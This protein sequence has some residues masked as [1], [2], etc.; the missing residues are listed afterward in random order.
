MQRY[1]YYQEYVG[2]C[3]WQK[4]NQCIVKLKFNRPTTFSLV[5]SWKQQKIWIWWR[6]VFM[7]NINKAWKRLAIIMFFYLINFGLWEIIA[8]VI[9]NEW[10]S[11]MVY[12]IL[13]SI[14]ITLFHR[15]LK[16]EWNSFR[17]TKL[18]FV[19]T[20]AFPPYYFIWA[21]C[22]IIRCKR[23]IPIRPFW[24]KFRMYFW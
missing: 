17:K 2:W 9:S 5:K 1:W 4:G 20:R 15:E 6:D 18:P 14:V 16:E 8:P 10:A 12:V 22:N 13:F 24:D 21:K 23:I 19:T 7:K 11:F 3:I